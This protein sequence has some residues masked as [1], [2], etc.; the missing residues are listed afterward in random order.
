MKSGKDK[1]LDFLKDNYP[2]YYNAPVIAKKL[3]LNPKSVNT[4][5]SRL[6]KNGLIIKQEGIDGFYRRLDPE[7]AE[8]PQIT[9]ECECPIVMHTF[10]C[11]AEIEKSFIETLT[12]L[13]KEGGSPP[14]TTLTDSNKPLLMDKTKVDFWL[15]LPHYWEGNKR[16][17]DIVIRQHHIRIE[18]TA[19]KIEIRE[20]SNRGKSYNLIELDKL[21]I[22]LE[23]LFYPHFNQFD[24]QF[25]LWALNKD[26]CE[27]RLE[28]VEAI[29]FRDV[30]G[31][32][33][34]WYAKN[35]LI[36]TREE[37]HATTE[38]LRLED[39]M[40][41]LN[42]GFKVPLGMADLRNEVKLLKRENQATRKEMRKL[43]HVIDRLL[44]EI[45]ELSGQKPLVVQYTK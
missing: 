35:N 28:G 19:L 12:M 1:V 32:I 40:A 37:V 24:W 42:S 26:H 22:A 33:Y 39:L 23:M 43:G 5:L 16:V 18:E 11:Y 13:D 7:E 31:A 15:H 14:P 45:H 30:K 38:A 25:P 8:K 41:V 34:R 10:Y 44:D 29:T 9:A 4:Y 3:R 20:L 2:D 17:R 6:A 36:P 27:I 21:L